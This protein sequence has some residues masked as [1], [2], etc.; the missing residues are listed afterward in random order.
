MKYGILGAGGIGSVHARHLSR[1]DDLELG[2]FD[3]DSAKSEEFEKKFG[4]HR[5]AS[6]KELIEHVDIVDICLPSDLHCEFALESIAAGR[7]VFVE[8][9][10]AK[11]VE[12]AARIVEAA[13][14]AAVPLGVGHVV[15]F[16]P[17]FAEGNRL[18]KA[19]KVGTPAAARTRRG[20]GTPGRGPDNWFLDHR[21]SGGVLIDLA[22]H[23]FDWLRWTLG[24]VRF[25][26]ARSVG[27]ATMSG[28]DYAL[29]TLTFESGAVAH[30]EATWMDPG[31]FRAAYEVCGSGG[32]IEWDSRRTVILR[33]AAGGSASG[34][35]PLAAA[36]DPY[37]RQLRAFIQAVKAGTNPPVAGYDGFMALSISHAALESAQT[38]NVVAPTRG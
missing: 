20:G 32:M 31:G 17:E 1:V 37:Y 3:V 24:E 5:Y 2:F 27:A 13:Q 10:L 33:T 21:R 34:E 35:S 9:P 29:A 36:D 22:V 15:R 30:V 23:D 12:D 6:A 16:F 25:L 19:G 38:G 18:V 8:K 28:P 11:T 4:A 7:A 26:Y 14:K